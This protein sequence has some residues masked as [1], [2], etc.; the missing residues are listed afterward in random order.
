MQDLVITGNLN[1]FKDNFG[2]ENLKE[3]EQFERFCFFSLLNREV[4]YALNPNDIDAIS[5]GYNKGID[6][7]A[8]VINDGLVKSQQEFEQVVQ[9]K[10]KISV[11]MFFIQ[12]K[13]SPSFDDKEMANF[14]DTIHD[15]LEE[16]PQYSF[17]KEAQSYHDIYILIMKNLRIVKDLQLYAFYAC[18]GNWNEGT[19]I[20]TTLQIKKNL[21][22]TRNIFS[23]IN[24]YPIDKTK[25]L[26]FYRKA[27]NPIEAEFSFNQKV[28]ISGIEGVEESY[29]GLLAFREFKKLIIEPN[30]N[31]IRNLFYDNVRDFLGPE[32]EVNDKI[33]D[34][35]RNKKFLEFALMNNGI[36]I[37]ASENSGR[38]DTFILHNYQ[39]VNGCQ[40]S[41]V[42]YECR[43]FQGIDDTLIPVKVI[44]TQDEG[45]RDKIILS[46]NSQSRIEEEELLALTKFQKELEE[47]YSSSSDGIFYERRNNQYSSRVDVKKKTIV[48]IREQIKSFVAMFLDEPH[49]VSGQFGKVYRERK[50]DIFIKDHFFEPYYIA[51]LIQYRFKEFL[52]IQVERKYNKARYHVFMM[53]RILN[54]KEIFSKDFLKSRKKKDYYETF[55]K[56]LRD[57]NACLESF[58]KVFNVIDI[59][60]IDIQDAKEI[61]KKSTTTLF[62]ETCKLKN[63]K[64]NK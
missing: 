44:V 11:V 48:D 24:I 27:S 10:Q 7:I 13:T 21:L 39:I 26:D 31:R 63:G 55:L 46:T 37:I 54:E 32:N 18:T 58:K 56:L 64:G 40:T 59:T 6:G 23:Q 34:T 19:S 51:G 41:N 22:E 60:K 52:D 36:T 61:Y 12:A 25:L 5:V 15:F 49:E 62:L 3:S 45:L 14:L 20:S 38:G 47:Y 17:T 50:N 53:F 9:S 43:D 4:R 28:S 16:K 29:V 2:F 35:I 1:S 57:K 42:L 33:Q 8:I 30:K